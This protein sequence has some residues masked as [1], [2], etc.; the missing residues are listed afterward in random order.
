[1]RRTNSSAARSSPARTLSRSSENGVD[2]ADSSERWTNDCR[3]ARP[4]QHIDAYD[5]Q[6]GERPAIPVCNASQCRL[7]GSRQH[8]TSFSPKVKISAHSR[9][10]IAEVPDHLAAVEHRLTLGISHDGFVGRVLDRCC[11][12]P[13][14]SVRLDV[15]PHFPLK[16][17]L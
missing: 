11:E 14:Q 16:H 12:F 13:G 15:P 5:I 8:S 7:P 2:I 10:S 4:G 1:Y 3:L 9:R 6:R 17:V